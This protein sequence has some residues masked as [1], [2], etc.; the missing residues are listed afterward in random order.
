MIVKTIE[1]ISGAAPWSEVRARFDAGFALLELL[2]SV[3]LV[4]LVIPFVVGL[5]IG[6][7]KMNTGSLE[8][9]A[10]VWAAQAKME[11]LW[12]AP[13]ASVVDGTEITSWATAAC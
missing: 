6:A 8:L 9:D 11:E 10:G 2:V 13:F 4:M 3:T 5:Q 7:M 1:L 12:L